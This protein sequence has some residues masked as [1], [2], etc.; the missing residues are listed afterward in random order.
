MIKSWSDLSFWSGSD[1]L[2]IQ[3]NIF[4]KQKHYIPA[5]SLV[6]KALEITP[7]SETK[8][9]ILG[10]DP[11]P[12][13]LYA[14]GLSFS[15]PRTVSGRLPPSLANIYT[16]YAS[17]LNLPV[18]THGDLTKWAEQG[19]LLWNCVPICK[20]KY[21]NWYEGLGFES[22][23]A[24]MIGT[25]NQEK[26]NVVFILWGAYAHKYIKLIQQDRHLV[27]KTVH[28]SPLSCYRGFFGSKPFTKTNTYL[29][30]NNIKPVDWN[31]N[32]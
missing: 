32:D 4:P 11:Y 26:E 6:F 10:Q 12:N 1:Y 2:N 15:I 28:P 24:E 25:L 22:L 16:E 23:T 8:V 19:V 14:M 5:R 27:I 3:K 18:P 31:L 7:F 9:V 20:P 17:D 21:S 29:T 30:E 13:P